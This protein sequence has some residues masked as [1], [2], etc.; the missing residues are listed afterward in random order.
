MGESERPRLKIVVT[1][2]R[3][4]TDED[5]VEEILL[6]VCRV[7]GVDPENVRLVNGGARGLDLMGRRVALRLGMT[8]QTIFAPWKRYREEGLFVK[9]AGHDRNGWMLDTDPD[10]VLAFHDRLESESKGTKNC[11]E[12]ARKRDLPVVVIN[13]SEHPTFSMGAAEKELETLQ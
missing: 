13:S 7:T 4:W 3:K 1:G 8:V 10:L 5:T 9:K 11:V 2:D 12:Q 6:I